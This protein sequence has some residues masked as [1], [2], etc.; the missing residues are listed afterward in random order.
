MVEGGARIV[1]TRHNRPVAEVIG[2]GLSGLHRGA[3]FG[4]GSIER[5]LE[6]GPGGIYLQILQEDRCGNR[7]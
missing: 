4:R 1:V 7:E 6:K 3:R 2:T 5:A